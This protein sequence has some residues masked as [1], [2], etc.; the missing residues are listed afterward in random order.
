MQGGV[1]DI[2]EETCIGGEVQTDPGPELEAFGE[3]ENL[4][5]WLELHAHGTASE[6]LRGSADHVNMASWAHL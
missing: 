6:M 2:G 5:S 4:V 3:R 1:V